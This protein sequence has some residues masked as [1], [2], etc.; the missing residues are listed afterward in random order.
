MFVLPLRGLQRPPRFRDQPL[1]SDP[2][3]LA[4]GLASLLLALEL[5]GGLARILRA[6]LGGRPLLRFG[7]A[8]SLRTAG[9]VVQVWQV[10]MLRE[11]AADPARRFRTT[12]GFAMVAATTSGS[13]VALAAPWWNRLLPAP[14]ASKAAFMDGATI[15]RS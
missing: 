1:A 11:A 6:D 7:T 15:A 13:S 12:P 10:G 4:R 2:L 5:R 14:H 8:P 3:F 9:L